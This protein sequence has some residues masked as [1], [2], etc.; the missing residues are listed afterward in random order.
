MRFPRVPQKYCKGV[1]GGVRERARCVL[2]HKLI[3]APGFQPRATL[4]VHLVDRRGAAQRTP[5]WKRSCRRFCECLATDPNCARPFMSDNSTVKNEEIIGLTVPQLVREV[6]HC[7]SIH[8]C[9]CCCE[10]WRRGSELANV[11]TIPTP[12]VIE[13]IGCYDETSGN[14]DLSRSMSLWSFFDKT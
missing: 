7:G 5:S 4:P 9:G 11:G 3:S 2:A 1:S 10:C 14:R 12:G 13:G 6:I 8:S